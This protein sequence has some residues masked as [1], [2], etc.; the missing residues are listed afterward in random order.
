MSRFDWSRLRPVNK[1]RVRLY[2]SKNQETPEEAFASILK[3][4]G[5]SE[6]PKICRYC[7]KNLTTRRIK[8]DK[9]KLLVLK[10]S[11]FVCSYKQRL[12]DYANERKLEEKC[13]LPP[14]TTKGIS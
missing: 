1:E 5:L 4:V 10:C 8:R 14:E 13:R 6:I 11:N 3:F 9:K 2:D 7:G 12:I